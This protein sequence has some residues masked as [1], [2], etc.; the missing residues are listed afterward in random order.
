M[1]NIQTDKALCSP[2][3]K[4][5]KIAR[6]YIKYSILV[7]MQMQNKQIILCK[8]PAHKG[9]KGNEET[10]KAANKQLISLE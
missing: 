6:Y 5:K 8:V 4:T 1:I 10:D 7:E 9:V 2:L 3:N